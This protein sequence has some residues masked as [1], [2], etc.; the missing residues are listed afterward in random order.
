MLQPPDDLTFVALGSPAQHSEATLLVNGASVGRVRRARGYL[1]I[2]SQAGIDW[3]APFQARSIRLVIPMYV[4]ERL[5]GFYGCGPP[6]QRRDYPPRVIDVLL[7]LAPAIAS[8]LEN[9]R[10]YAT[11]AQLN[12]QLRALDQLKDE[13]IENVAHELRTPLTCLS[14]TSQLL[15]SDRE[16]MLALAQVMSNGVT[17]ARGAGQSGAAV[18]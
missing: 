9:A 3:A 10:A 11:I 5:V 15:M 18:R 7:T 12:Q 6:V 17:R 16:L 14:L 8:A 4:G 13:F 1:T 2:P